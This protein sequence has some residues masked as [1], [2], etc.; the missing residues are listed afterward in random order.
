MANE[1]NGEE[2]YGWRE[3]AATGLKVGGKDESKSAYRILPSG[4]KEVRENDWLNGERENLSGAGGI[5]QLYVHLVHQGLMKSSCD[6]CFAGI[7]H[8]SVNDSRKHSSN[9]AVNL[10]TEK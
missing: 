10:Y 5:G 6:S 7:P 8:H 9:S 1:F 2:E 4:R 3:C